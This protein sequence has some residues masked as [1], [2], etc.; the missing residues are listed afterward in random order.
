[1][2]S[3]LA[4][5]LFSGSEVPTVG[6]IEPVFAE[7][8][9]RVEL[10]ELGRGGTLGD[11]LW[12][13]LD[14][15]AQSSFLLALRE[16]ANPRRLQPGTEVAFRWFTAPPSRLRSVDITLDADRTV[17]IKPSKSGWVSSVVNTPVMTDT[18]WASGEIQTSLWDAVINS[19]GLAGV[20]PKD[21][22]KF[23]LDLDNIFQWQ[24]DFTRAIRPGDF[25]R[26]S[27]EREVRP[28]GTMRVGHVLSAELVNRGRVLKAIWFDPNGDGAG[29]YYDEDGNSV[30][31]AFLMSPIAIGYRIS[32][33]FTNSRLH[34]VLRTWRA[35][36]GVDFAAPR[37][38]PVQATGNG[39][40]IE[41]VRQ[42]TYGNTILIRHSNG[43]TT[44]YAHMNRFQ[45]SVTVG[46]RVD[47]GDII[48][49]VGMTGL[50]TGPHLH[51]EMR[52]R[53]TPRDPQTV[54][55]PAG[56]PVPVDQWE[57]WEPQ[58]RVRMALLDRLPLPWDV[59]L[60]LN[61][62]T[63]SDGPDVGAR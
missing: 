28:D 22:A 3:S 24:V 61:V 53:G 12:G 4:F 2:A 21:K 59:Q 50:A 10:R 7:A 38:T 8:P 33:G 36:R 11:L 54:E 23:F 9:E 6:L 63:D 26:F 57:L 19:E 45:S 44:R 55:L 17:R 29:T 49:Y 31:R 56:D 58:S 27:L 5:V 41:R 25:Y 15:N 39:V 18:V 32:S 62:L 35:H 42:N 14:A 20:D 40:V 47:Q 51:Y 46:S 60:A 43:W 13:V 16:Q 37:G 48:G 52:I 34:P 30:R 1:M